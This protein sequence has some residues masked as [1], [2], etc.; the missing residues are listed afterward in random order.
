MRSYV[1]PV[2]AAAAADKREAVVRAAVALL[3]GAQDLSGFS[4]EAVARAAGVTRLTV[5]K[6]FGSR[7]GLLEAVFDACAAQAGLERLAGVMAQTDPRAALSGV[8]D[9]FCDFWTEPAV[10]RLHQA[11]VLDAELAQALA[12]RGERRRRALTV[13][14]GRA[15][16]EA[17]DRAW[18]D[19]IDLLFGLTGSAM[20]EAL[21]AGRTRAEAADIVKA[22]ALAALDRL[23]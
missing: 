17:G 20:F 6:Q 19:T 16:P 4:L 14:V 1:S 7:R 10:V 11:G 15:A 13:I 23:N 12:A 2:R 8:I 9:V 18:R 22:A 5:Y 21:A 3:R